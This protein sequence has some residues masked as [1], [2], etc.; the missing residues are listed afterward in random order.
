[1]LMIP[2]SPLIILEEKS[3]PSSQLAKCI[4][5]QPSVGHGISVRLR[6]GRDFPLVW[7]DFSTNR[8]LDCY[9]SIPPFPKFKWSKCNTH[10][11]KMI[12]SF[13]YL[14]F[15]P[16]GGP[17]LRHSLSIFGNSSC[18]ESHQ[19]PRDSALYGQAIVVVVLAVLSAFG[20]VSSISSWFCENGIPLQTKEQEQTWMS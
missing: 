8:F 12:V 10:H 1:M 3:I 5:S 18:K 11:I 6:F 13:E 14:V 2:P 7:L 4:I 20:L 9:G 15:P 16:A 17:Q 19:C